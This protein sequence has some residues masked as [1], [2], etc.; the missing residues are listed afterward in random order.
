MHLTLKRKIK[1]TAAILPLLAMPA[2]MRAQDGT[3]TSPQIIS[4]KP[5]LER[6]AIEQSTPGSSPRH[7]L[8]PE[9]KAVYAP[10]QA[11]LDTL[12]QRNYE[13]IRHH[14]LPGGMATLVRN[15]Q[16][17]QLHFDAFIDRLQHLPFPP[18]LKI[19]ET[20]HDP[21]VHIDDDIAVLWAP[22]T[23]TVDGKID[24]CG[25]NIIT[26]IRRD[27]RWLISNIADNSKKDCTNK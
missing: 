1:L 19:E 23:V 26:L 7:E 24:H 27:G 13:Q 18:N 21:I 2:S 6:S 12:P 17:N 10:F 25:T 11:L 4:S 15:G 14:L 3:N 9:E 20:V 5:R 8:T 16:P 22:Y